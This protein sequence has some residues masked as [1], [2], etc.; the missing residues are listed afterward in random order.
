MT[1]VLVGKGHLPAEPHMSKSG[2][3]QSVSQLVVIIDLPCC[4]HHF[5]DSQWSRLVVNNGGAEVEAPRVRRHRQASSGV[6]V[7]RRYPPLQP[8]RGPC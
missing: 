8:T 6:E 4:L 1:V 2:P 7:R 3:N 5:S